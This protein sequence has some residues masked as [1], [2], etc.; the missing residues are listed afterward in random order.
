[1]TQLLKQGVA[2]LIALMISL[3]TTTAKQPR[4]VVNIV[5]GSL[6]A[7]D[8]DRYADNFTFGGF[9]RLAREGVEY[10]NARYDYA[11]TTTASG[12]ATLSTGAQPSAHGIVGDHW[13]N[14]VDSSLV[15][16][17][18]DNKVR[19]VEF[20]TG[21]GNYSPVRL[22][23]ATVGDM[24]LYNDSL[25]KQYTIA[26][27]PLSAIL[28]NG[29]RG[30]ALWAE[31][32]QT[33]WVTSSY[34]TSALPAWLKLYNA[35]DS[36][37]KHTLRR[38][39]PLYA[40]PLYHNEEVAVVEGI[41]NKST[42]LISGIDLKL[43]QDLYGKMR[44]TPAGNTMVMELASILFVIENLG[45]DEHTDILN[46]C[47]DSSRYIAE[48]Y[49]PESIEYE[50]MLYRLDKSLADFLTFLYAQFDDPEDVV[51]VLSSDHGTSPAYNPVGGVARERFNVSQ[52]MVLVNA[53]LGA[54]YGSTDY[55]LGFA[56]NALYLDH[57]LLQERRIDLETV[58]EEVAV[59]MLQLRGVANALS[60]S[61]LRNTAFASGRSRLLQQSFVPTRSGDVVIDFM[62]GWTIEDSNYRSASHAGYYYDRRVPLIISHSGDARRIDREVSITQ[63]APTLANILG[64]EA[65]WASEAE[66]LAEF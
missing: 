43:S 37:C 6:K 27:D 15:E 49:G 1:M 40:A 64:I 18:V 65:P 13:W 24:L 22:T 54:R 59:F 14:Y 51:V 32:N 41:K 48:T 53:F 44:Y 4:V 52:M 17:I 61:S 8:L 19:P 38:W 66:P 39:T 57:T 62:P 7:S 45:K 28:L 31:K 26:I 10:T 34:Y 46:I 55:I 35:E 50:D 5:V 11:L 20:S 16:L 12:L 36:N 23:A 47:L 33:H 2:L 60:A 42:K 9:R 30:I 56:N 21:T 25:S 29:K 3:G 58:R 63:V